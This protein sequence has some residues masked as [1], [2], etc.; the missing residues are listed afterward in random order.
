[1]PPYGE[2]LRVPKEGDMDTSRECFN[3]LCNQYV[4]VSLHT[5]LTKNPGDAANVKSTMYCWTRASWIYSSMAVW[6]L[7]QMEYMRPLGGMVPGRSLIALRMNKS[8]LVW[9]I[10]RSLCGFNFTEDQ[11]DPDIL[12]GISTFNL[13]S[14]L[15]LGFSGIVVDELNTFL[16]SLVR[17]MIQI[18]T[19]SCCCNHGISFRSWGNLWER[20]YNLS[21][22]S[23]WTV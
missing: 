22:Y 5:F 17:W 6:S 12:W 21:E 19:G 8:S 20:E 16:G 3:V 23:C 13:S 7:G 2:E 1:M 10:R 11:V 4:V 15:S 9:M 18:I 14:G